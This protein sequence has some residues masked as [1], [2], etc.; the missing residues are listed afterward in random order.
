MEDINSSFNSPVESATQQTPWKSQWKNI[1][2]AM[3]SYK[4]QQKFDGSGHGIG[5]GHHKAP[6][7]EQSH[8]ETRPLFM[9]PQDV[10][11][12]NPNATVLSSSKI[13]QM[14]G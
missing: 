6:L 12:D 11:Y 2:L 13:A 1:S 4:S 3:Q 9:G 8:I 14:P 7:A 5:L 10:I